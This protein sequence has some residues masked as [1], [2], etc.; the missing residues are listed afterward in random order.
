MPFTNVPYS[1]LGTFFP[2]CASFSECVCFSIC[3]TPTSEGFFVYF[4][5]KFLITACR[6]V[7]HHWHLNSGMLHTLL[8]AVWKHKCPCPITVVTENSSMLIIWRSDPF[9]RELCQNYEERRNYQESGCSR[10][11]PEGGLKEEQSSEHQLWLKSGGPWLYFTLKLLAPPPEIINK[12]FHTH[13]VL[14]VL[15]LG[16]LSCAP[17]LQALCTCRISPCTAAL[18]QPAPG[19]Q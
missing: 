1:L 4:P 10:M 12:Q 7:K 3:T 9:W 18:Y 14:C 11:S 8:P 16:L 17:S 5:A 6:H 2:L 19:L 15:H 13:F